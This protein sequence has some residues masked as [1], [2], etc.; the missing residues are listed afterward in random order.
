MVM[1]FVILITVF[2]Y[3]VVPERSYVVA[4]SHM[5]ML[6]SFHRYLEWLF[7]RLEGQCYEVAVWTFDCFGEYSSGPFSFVAFYAGRAAAAWY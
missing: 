6:Y 2:S 5:E 3:S 7:F 4:E 1:G